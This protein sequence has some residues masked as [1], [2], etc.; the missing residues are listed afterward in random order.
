MR[1]RLNFLMAI[2]FTTLAGGCKKESHVNIDSTA[3]WY[4]IDGRISDLRGPYYVRITKSAGLVTGRPSF[5]GQ[6]YE[7]AEPVK[8]AQVIISDDQGLSDTLVPSP[9]RAP[10]RYK[11]FRNGDKLDSLLHDQDEAYFIGDRGYYETTKLKGVPGRTY[12]LQVRIGD[13]NFKASAYMPSVPALDSATLKDTTLAGYKNAGI[14]PV[15]WFR[16]PQEEENYYLLQYNHTYFYRYDYFSREVLLSGNTVPFY[17]LDDKI[18]SPEI[19]SLA[20]RV[21]ISNQ[22][23]Y[24][25]EYYP[26][27]RPQRDYPIQVK[28]SSLTKEAYD[29]Y[30][31][32]GKQ[33]QN[34]G[35]VYQPAPGS[36]TGNISGGALGLFYATSVSWKVVLP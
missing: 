26:Y 23:E 1:V 13:E 34:D 31:A 3:T 15:I 18:L 27:I 33:L 24:G 14:I 12:Q 10:E 20:V 30:N 36:A 22:K 25:Y 4:V 29:F 11:Y 5:Y 35:N 9:K 28:L 16:E 7:G 32:L 6:D 19:K 17:V 2:C 8:G 21:L